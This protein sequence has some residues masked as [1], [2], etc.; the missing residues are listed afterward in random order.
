MK[1]TFAQ[2]AEQRGQFLD[3]E[4]LNDVTGVLECCV[5]CADLF[6]DGLAMRTGG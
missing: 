6:W 1:L 5:D 4:G 2:M 3:G